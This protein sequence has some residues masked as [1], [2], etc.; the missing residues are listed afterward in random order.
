V[1]QLWVTAGTLALAQCLYCAQPPPMP[2][3]QLIREVVY[4]ELQDHK[5]HG[6]WRYWIDRHT[7]GGTQLDDQVETAQGPL[8]RLA[9]TNGRALSPEAQQQEQARLRSLVNSPE[10]QTRHRRDY[11]DDESNIGHI[12]ALLPTAFLVEYDGE[13]NGCHRLR[14][15]PNPA[16]PTHSIEDRVFHAMSGTLW[17]DTRS[18]RLV[19]L[20]AHLEQ[21][22]DFAF[23][24]LGRLYKGGWFQVRRVQVST[25]EWK[26]EH[27][28]MHMY[29]RAM[30]FKSIARESSEARGGFAP[31][32]AGMNLAQ[33]MSLLNQA[34]ILASFPAQHETKPQPETHALRVSASDLAARP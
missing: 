19:R 3:S 16:Y 7:S 27:V 33:A 5:S 31:V 23:G 25:T 13:E 28:E 26:T 4:N 12:V 8:T 9:L 1:R 20:D 34:E 6:Y 14:F 22:V 30:L 24:L 15:R 18:K 29:G 11:D 10:E 32:P 2:A 21:N 17:I